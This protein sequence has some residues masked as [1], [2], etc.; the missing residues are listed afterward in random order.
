MYTYKYD[1]YN[2]EQIRYGHGEDAKCTNRTCG[3]NIW[4]DTLIIVEEDIPPDYFR[5]YVHVWECNNCG[6]HVP[7]GRR[8]AKEN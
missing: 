7:R 5:E 2:D 6:T 4:T 1:K 3:G 8:P